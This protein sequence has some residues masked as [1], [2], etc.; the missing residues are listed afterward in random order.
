[1]SETITIG[2]RLPVV[3]G[4][5]TVM[6]NGRR[7]RRDN[8]LRMTMPTQPGDYC[9]P[10]VGYTGNLPAVFFLKPNARD[11]GVPPR[12]RSVQHVVSPPHVFR[13]CPD[14]SLEIRQSISNLMRGDV[15]GSS[16]DGL[17]VAGVPFSGVVFIGRGWRVGRR[18]AS[19]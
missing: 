8:V 17:V 15:D 6:I 4:S 10:V 2:R 18:G 19:V 16:D 9:G 11:E 7:I 14:G 3:T 13:E 5:M 1:M 12:A